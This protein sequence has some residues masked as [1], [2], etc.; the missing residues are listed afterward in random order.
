[1]DYYFGTESWKK[2]K[3]QGLKESLRQLE[4]NRHGAWR[5]GQR[6]TLRYRED[7]MVKAK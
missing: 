1:M 3:A 2:L 7:W 6:E 5:I 4:A